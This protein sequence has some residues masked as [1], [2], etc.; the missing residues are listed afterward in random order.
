MAMAVTKGVLDSVRK[1][2]LKLRMSVGRVSGLR[3]WPP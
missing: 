3:R 1:A 2:N